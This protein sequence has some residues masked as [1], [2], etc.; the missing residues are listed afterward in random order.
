MALPPRQPVRM[1]ANFDRR[2]L[3]AGKQIAV[4]PLSG[5]LATLIG[6][7]AAHWGVFEGFF[8]QITRSIAEQAGRLPEFQQRGFERRMRL[9]RNMLRDFRFADA[10]E[11]ADE[12]FAAILNRA[13]ELQWQRNI[14]VHGSYSATILPMSN[15]G[16]FRAT[17]LHNRREVTIDLEPEALTLLWHDIAHLTGALLHFGQK[18]GTYEGGIVTLIAADDLLALFVE[19]QLDA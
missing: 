15:E 6:L 10:H 17:G 7:V 11:N 4:L 3:R 18:A 13:K 19:P 16:H 14:V 2:Y 5:E 8:N 12:E 9:L 1:E